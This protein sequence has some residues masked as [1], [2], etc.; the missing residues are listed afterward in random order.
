MIEI[1]DIEPF[2]DTAINSAMPY[3]NYGD[4]YALFLGKYNNHSIYRSLLQ[5]N[6]PALVDRGVIE[7]VELL[8]YSIR[9]DQPSYP[10]EFEIYRI[11]ENFDEN[12]V[13][14][15]SQPAIDTILYR[16]FTIEDEVDTYIKV[17]ITKLFSDWYC[18]KY[19]NNGLLIKSV[20]E[21]KNSLVAFYSKDGFETLYKPKLKI[22]Y[23][24]DI[25]KQAIK[26]NIKNSIKAPEE[27]YHMGNAY[28]EDKDYDKAYKYYNKAYEK[29]IPSETYSPK[30]LIR[31]VTTLN[32]L[33][34]YDEGLKITDYGLKEYIDF[35]ELTF[36]RGQLFYK[37]N[38]TSLAIKEFNKC[39]DMGE[40]P[41]HL[42][43]IA[44]AGTFRAYDALA[45]IYFN[46]KD[47]DEAYQYCIKAVTVNPKYIQ[48]LNIIVKILIDKER[49]MNDI[50]L[51]LEN[52]FGT[53]LDGKD[54]LAIADIFFRQREYKIAYEYFL[55]AD[56][57]CQNSLKVFYD[58]GMCLLFLKN[59]QEAYKNFKKIKKGKLY[60]NAIYNMF[61]CEILSS[62]MNNGVRLLNMVRD[63]EHNN[64]RIVYYAF[65]NLI[66]GK[67]CD[68]ISNDKKESE[69]FLDDIFD[70]LNIVIK[71]APPE[72][73]QKSLQLLNLVENDEVLLRLAK[74]YCNNGFY[75]LAYQEFVRSIKMFNKI[76]IEGLKMMT[77]VY[78]KIK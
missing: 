24:K 57:F 48:P 60:E 2:K 49:D 32:K 61:L 58:K 68:I 56:E 72:I 73:F 21:D 67:K 43:F 28:F 10:K 5:F 74:L 18:E 53:N 77:K 31:M 20:N 17:D 8:L 66:E 69:K 71:S 76:D 46:L 35:T 78:S 19:P 65:K 54:Y 14:Y 13:T 75:N 22:Y 39:V 25:G 64:T 7:K 16:T 29:F 12:T 4:Y 15:A 34:M 63:P 45:E 62:N 23:K 44:G 26:K 36:L 3:E 55:K 9:N 51:K 27:Y 38:K 37:Q 52:F 11:N 41:L 1:I 50:K 40:A 47:Y 33:E 59:Y 70:L 42:N 30:L 6:L